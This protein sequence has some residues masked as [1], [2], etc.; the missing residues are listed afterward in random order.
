M[1]RGMS[2]LLEK[3]GKIYDDG[4]N[5]AKVV[6]AHNGIRLTFK[7]TTRPADKPYSVRIVHR[8]S[9]EKIPEQHFKYMVLEAK[10]LLWPAEKTGAPS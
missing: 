4:G 10:R 6:L 1:N 7:R 3:G 5:L 2:Y 8:S 9:D